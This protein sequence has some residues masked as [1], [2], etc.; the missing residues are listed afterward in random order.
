MEGEGLT[1]FDADAVQDLLL[2]PLAMDPAHTAH[3]GLAFAFLG[4]AQQGACARR[5]AS[6]GAPISGH[7]CRGSR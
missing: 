4:T 2:I 1:R 6:H 7:L 5:K 3:A